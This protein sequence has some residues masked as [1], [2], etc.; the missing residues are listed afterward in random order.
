LQLYG[1]IYRRALFPLWDR[2]A[3]PS[4]RYLRRLEQSQ[5]CSPEELAR[6]QGT[7][8]QRLLR[9]AYAN[10][11]FY[12]ERLDAAGVDPSRI[13]SA[14]DLQS[15]P[16]LDRDGAQESTPRRKSLAPPFISVTK[17]T[18]GSTGQ[19][20]EFGYEADSEA[21]RQAIRMRGY[22]WAGY[23][24]GNRTLHLWSDPPPKRRRTW[25]RTVRHRAWVATDRGLRRDVYVDATVRSE[26]LW[27][28]SVELIRRKRPRTIVCYS[29]AGVELA[30][31]VVASD[32]RD[33]ETIPVICGAEPL[34]PGDRDILT[35]AFG[36]AVFETYGNREVMLMAT[37]CEA[38]EGLHLQA[39]N[40]VVE[41]VVREQDADEGRP[42]APGEVGEV[43][44]TD[45]HNLAMPFIRYVTGDLA[46]AA[47][48]SPC[49]CGRGLPRIASVEGRTSDF[50]E[51]SAGREV[52]GIA[53]MTLFVELAPAV[54]QF[55]VVQRADR[56][57]TVRVV[58]TPRFDDSTRARIHSHCEHYLPGVPVT[59]DVVEA[60]DPGPGG[61]RRFVVR[62]SG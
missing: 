33:W 20:L 61:K 54:R 25:W 35:Q 59:I 34:L 13:A 47:D 49:R 24:E 32:L 22:G 4:L 19:P 14:A 44:V 55:Q 50:L 27:N 21:W 57:L 43:V 9:H 42:A 29:Q 26:E 10:V 15:I 16:L 48:P 3:R 11:P 2:K 53:L 28:R 18:S 1:E 37:E 39:E 38:H 40:L 45:L 62:E 5:W 31:Y 51:D 7:E 56:S 52:S 41:V 6:F 36:P 12:R 30:R 17:N 58:P 23:R 46:A 8:L 60:I